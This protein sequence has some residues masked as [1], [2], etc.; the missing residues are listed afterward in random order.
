[1]KK[2]LKICSIILCLSLIFSFSYNTLAEDLYFEIVEITNDGNN[3]TVSC[4]IEGNLTSKLTLICSGEDNSVIYIEELDAI[5]Y[6][7]YEITFPILSNSDSQKYTLSIGGNDFNT[8][9]SKSFYLIDTSSPQYILV[10]SIKTVAEL[11]NT[12]KNNNASVY[13][14]GVLLA[15]DATVKSLDTISLFHG[16]KTVERKAVV[17][18]DIN[19]DGDVAAA[20]ALLALQ[21]TVDKITISGMSFKAADIYRNGVINSECALK[22]LQFSVNKL[23]RL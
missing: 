21:H 11:K 19:L 13:R 2:V 17:M 18:G 5:N 7:Y 15:N 22:I 6:G 1:M 10:Y 20:D 4:Q 23:T 9:I 14:N 8:P 16:S 3:V 12:L